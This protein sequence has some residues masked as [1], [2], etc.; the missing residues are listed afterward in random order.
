MKEREA[1]KSQ[2][3]EAL[4]AK[5]KLRKDAEEN[6]EIQDSTAH[7]SSDADATDAM[8]KATD[9]IEKL[10]ARL[11]ERQ[12]VSTNMFPWKNRYFAHGPEVWPGKVLVCGFCH[13]ATTNAALGFR[14][15]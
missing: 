13:T 4:L 3:I 9:K 15:D 2:L 5:E 12:Q 11:K 10:R 1:Q 8:K 14:S 6:R 7:A